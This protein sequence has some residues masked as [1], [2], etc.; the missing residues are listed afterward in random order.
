MSPFGSRGSPCSPTHN[1]ASALGSMLPKSL[2]AAKQEACPLRFRDWPWDYRPTDASGWQALPA[3]PGSMLVE[4][5]L[6]CERESRLAI[7]RGASPNGSPSLKTLC[8]PRLPCVS[9]RIRRRSRS[10]GPSDCDPEVLP[11]RRMRRR[12][13]WLGEMNAMLREIQSGN[14]PNVSHV[15][16]NSPHDVRELALHC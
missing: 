12:H 15:C 2:L 9:R 10:T 3:L 7:A 1:G 16:F 13:Q 6:G 14:L 4:D 11:P 8:I 5:W